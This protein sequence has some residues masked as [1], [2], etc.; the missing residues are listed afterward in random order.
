MSDSELLSATDAVE[1]AIATLE[2]RRHD[3]LRRIDETGYAK[4]LGAHDTARLIEKRYRLDPTEARRRVRLATALPKYPAVAAALPTPGTVIADDAVVLHTAQADAIVSALEKIPKSA[5]V[6]VEE[7]D[8]A[9]E[10]MVQAARH[11]NPDQLRKLGVQVRNILDTDGPEP[12]EAAARHREDVWIKKA[13]DGVK[14]GGYLAGENA[15]KLQ[16]VLQAGAKPH[17]TPDG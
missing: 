12:R 5:N 2:A 15:E 17:K 8:A 11:M 3:L 9:A 14:F 1:E 16:T 4:E 13:D 7:L 10:Q 6:P